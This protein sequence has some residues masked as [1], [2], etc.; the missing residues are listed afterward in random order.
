VEFQCRKKGV[1][2]AIWQPQYDPLH[3]PLIV[4]D[5][6]GVSSYTCYQPDGQVAYTE[7][8]L[9]HAWDGGSACA[10]TPPSYAD[11]QTY[12]ADGNAVTITTH[13]GQIAGSGESLGAGVTQRFYDAADRLVETIS[14]RDPTYDLYPF[15]WMMRYIYDLGG[16][17]TI[18]YLSPVQG[19]GNLYKTQECLPTNPVID[20]RAPLSVA[21]GCT[22]QDVRGSSFDALD[23][24][25]ASYEVA[26]GS[27]PKMRNTYDGPGDAGLLTSSVNATG[28]AT[29][30]SYDADGKVIADTFSDATPARSFS[31]DPDGHTVA[32]SSPSWGTQNYTVTVC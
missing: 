31:Y 8:A 25:T 15:P 9:Q 2:G 18:A 19:Y 17:D 32:V 13:N 20:A 27:I 16:S 22:F 6:D 1:N 24:A 10:S 7:T 28:Q 30:I 29:S 26:F 12:D 3:Q 23:R 14:P 4:T 11:A 21:P 5:P